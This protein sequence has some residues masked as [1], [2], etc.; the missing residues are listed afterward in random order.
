[1]SEF[2]FDR[3][4]MAVKAKR[5]DEA[6]SA[7]E[8]AL[9]SKYTV[10]GWT[11]LGICKLFQLADNQTMEEVIY[12]FSKAKEVEGANIRE[13]DLQLISYSH[14]VIE[15]LTG[16]CLALIERIIVAEKEKMKAAITATVAS[17]IFSD[18]KSRS[19][20]MISGVVAGAA[21]G[22]AYGKMAEIN[23]KKQAGQFTLNII[24]EINNHVNSFLLDNKLL[25]EA[26]AFN[27][28]VIEL[29]K[30]IESHEENIK[31]KKAIDKW[32]NNF[33]YAYVVKKNPNLSE[34]EA[35]KKTKLYV[36]LL[37]VAVLML[38]SIFGGDK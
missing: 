25:D 27:N 37:T 20:I 19:T 13:I 18:A 5:Y 2:Q 28:R 10:E 38:A 34:E 30:M 17:S 36:F 29:T 3:A 21:A 23:D 35:I 6:Q 16:Y 14:L 24:S 7:Y 4:F 26:K 31:N 15:Q 33:I 32:K 1:M 12:C 11:G 9:D 8:K 22:V